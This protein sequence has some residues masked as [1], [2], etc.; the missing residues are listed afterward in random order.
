MN[1]YLEH[2]IHTLL[3][4]ERK[5]KYNRYNFDS[6]YITYYYIIIVIILNLCYIFY[7]HLY[8]FLQ[9]LYGIK[10]SNGIATYGN[11]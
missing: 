4:L 6:Y 3:V 10:R 9:K 1:F 5:K 8:F 2:Y 7:F 11:R